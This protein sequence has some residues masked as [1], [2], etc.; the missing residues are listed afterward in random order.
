MTFISASDAFAS[1]RTDVNLLS[2]HLRTCAYKFNPRYSTARRV[3]VDNF[4]YFGADISDWDAG[5]SDGFK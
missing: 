4:N 3:L 2:D 1:G 5:P